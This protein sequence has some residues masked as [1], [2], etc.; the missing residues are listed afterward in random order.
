VVDDRGSSHPQTEQGPSVL[1]YI[2]C[3][4]NDSSVGIHV[5]DWSDPAAGPVEL[6]GFDDIEH[7]SFLAAHPSGAVLYAVSETA[8]PEGGSVTALRIDPVDG[9]LTTIDRVSSHGGAP[10][11]VSV[12]ADGGHLYVAN[13]ASGTV[14]AYALE[15]DG[16]FGEVIAVHQHHGSG[17]T[18][19][20][21]GAHAHC[22]VP[23]PMGGSVYAADLGTDCV[24]RYLHD[25]H[26]DGETFALI[27]ELRLEAG[28]GPRQLAFHPE[29]P[30]GFLICELD[31]TIVTLDLDP[32]DG[33][34]TRRAVTSTLPDD[35][36]TE[37]IAAE[38]RVHP[39]GRYVYASNRGH[40]SIAVFAFAGPGKPLE[41]L[42]Y[43][44][45]GGRTPRSFAVHPSGRALL[46]ANQNSNTVVPF[47]IDVATGMPRRVHGTCDVSEPVCLTVVEVER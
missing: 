10:C 34:L 23:G 35:T 20:Q 13:Y 19:R 28:A 32:V 4:T 16:R 46:V 41:P 37:S 43:V 36:G 3:Y 8:R 2:G 29:L 45:S 42:G 17:P 12:D 39:T 44:D 18:G 14:A 38:V 15:P 9:S 11:H 6:S 24:Y 7:P 31:S 22:I 26:H 27:D 25:R 21:D 30:V 40:D 1:L 47:D 33:R 5:H